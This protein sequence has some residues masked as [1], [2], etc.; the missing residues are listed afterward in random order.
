MRIG[1]S[2]NNV[3]VMLTVVISITTNFRINAS[4][5]LEMVKKEPSARVIRKFL[6]ANLLVELTSLITT[7]LQDTRIIDG[8]Y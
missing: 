3:N 8:H 6:L 4:S 7:K 5:S 2:S 1:A